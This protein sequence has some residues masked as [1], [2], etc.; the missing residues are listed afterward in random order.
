MFHFLTLNLLPFMSLE[1]SNP[2]LMI[3][4]SS[5]KCPVPHLAANQPRL[6]IPGD[7][8]PSIDDWLGCLESMIFGGI[9]LG[10]EPLD[11]SLTLPNPQGPSVTFLDKNP[12]WCKYGYIHTHQYRYT[13]YLHYINTLYIHIHVYVYIY[14]YFYIY[15]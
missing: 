6:E 9:N 11:G 14:F 4:L 13:T 5:T 8:L 15:L 7:G 1:A 12:S 3:P 10:R 2:K